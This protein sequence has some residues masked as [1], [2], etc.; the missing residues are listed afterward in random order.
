MGTERGAGAVQ[1]IAFLAEP[2]ERVARR[3][4]SLAYEA[5]LAAVRLVMR[6]ALERASE[7]RHVARV[8]LDGGRERPGHAGS[9]RAL[10]EGGAPVRDLA[11]VEIEDPRGLRE[12]RV[13]RDLGGDVRVP[14]HVRADP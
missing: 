5:E 2:D 14:V 1:D 4:E 13:D 12:G 6:L 10:R 11:G 8:V 7:L 9:H 3:A